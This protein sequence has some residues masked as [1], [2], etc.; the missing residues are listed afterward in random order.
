MTLYNFF[1]MFNDS[2]DYFI[3]IKTDKNIDM[4]GKY[5]VIPTFHEKKLLDLANEYVKLDNLPSVYHLNYYNF[6][7]TLTYY[8]KYNHKDFFDTALE[9]GSLFDKEDSSTRLILTAK[10]NNDKLLE[11]K[12]ITIIVGM[13]CLYSLDG[14][15]IKSVNNETKHIYEIESNLISLGKMDTFNL[16]LEFTDSII[17]DYKLDVH[18]Q[19]IKKLN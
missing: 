5:N 4:I 16:T 6:W 2:L 12:H 11:I 17:D 18:I 15:F 10:N 7:K 9:F 3:R 14:N 13:S 19:F 8:K 1:H